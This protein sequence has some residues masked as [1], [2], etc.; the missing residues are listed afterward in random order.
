MDRKGKETSPNQERDSSKEK[1]PTSDAM[2]VRGDAAAGGG[3]RQRYNSEGGASND[4]G[5]DQGKRNS[6]YMVAIY[7]PTVIQ[8]HF[9]RF[10]SFCWRKIAQGF[11]IP[12]IAASP[13]KFVSLEE[14]MTA[15]N[16]MN[17]M[18]L[19]HEIAV[20]QDFK[21]KNIEPPNDSIHR[22]VKDTIHKAFWDVLESELNEDPPNYSQ[23]MVLLEDVKQNLISL[24][25]PQHTKIK[26][27]I[28]EA[29]DAALIR[30][31]V[32]RRV[33][34]FQYYAQYVITVMG[35]LCAPVRDEKIKELTEIQGVVPMFRGIL[36]TLD[37]MKLD[38]AN[39]TIDYFRPNII[40]KSVEYEKQKFA[41]FLKIQTDGLQYTRRWL[42]EHVMNFRK[43]GEVFNVEDANAI[44]SLTTNV[45]GEAYLELLDWNNR[46][47]YP[48][49]LVMDQGRFTELGR[50]CLRLHI[51]G[52][53]L[54]VTASTVQPLYGIA[55][56][57]EKLKEHIKV[58]MEDNYTNEDLENNL[59]NI[60]EQVVK[61]VREGLE[62]YEM[63]PLET[64]VEK[65]LRGQIMEIARE[66]HK[67][68]HLVR[69]RVKEFLLQTVTSSTAAPLRIP[70]G[71]SSLQTE[72]TSITGQFL[73]LV[74][75]NRAVFGEYYTDIITQAVLP[76]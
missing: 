66:D 58:L 31:Q 65:M 68:R 37:L 3:S 62:R 75:H 11:T 35:K 64:S 30:Q 29:L 72:L 5:S 44:R 56:F 36:E 33:L 59:P 28:H 19:A 57:K 43:N 24:L 71:L 63:K 76:K 51:T 12:G 16:G 48:E 20:D 40:A 26:E 70:L 18:V 50:R 38:M 4:D 54:L 17:N 7:Y 73:R 10:Y 21:L 45:L 60:T 15:A 9:F 27:E 34:D 61:E 13:P 2:D 8:D 49:T 41:E 52:S 22:Q 55:A 42:V 74:S 32:E 47:P 46:N 1:S 53:V 6:E 67:I 69:M 14:I 39:F 25:L 23:A